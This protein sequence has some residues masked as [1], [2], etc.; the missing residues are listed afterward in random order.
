MKDKV[1]IFIYNRK[2]SKFLLVF[3]KY[4]KNSSRKGCFTMAGGMKDIN[5]TKEMIKKE[6]KDEIGLDVKEIL[7]LNWGS[8]YK[9]GD[10]EFKEMNFIAFVDSNNVNL[11]GKCLNCKWLDI[12]GFVKEVRFGESA[13]LLRKVLEK[14]I[15]GE[16]YFDKRERES[17]N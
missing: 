6:I 11:N 17:L 9:L 15:S 12:N 1:L 7:P 10:E 2:G 3:P 5:H 16:L 14:G 13:T 8:T 4:Q